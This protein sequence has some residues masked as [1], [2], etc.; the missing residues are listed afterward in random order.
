M[1]TQYCIRPAFRR[2]TALHVLALTASSFK[3]EATRVLLDAGAKPN[4]QDKQDRTVAHLLLTGKFPWYKADESLAMLLGAGTDFSLEDDRGQTPLHYLA[5]LGRDKP[6][7]FIRGITNCFASPKADISARDH[8]GDTPMHIAARTGTADGFEWLRAR[9][10]SLE[11]TN[12][13]GETPLGLAAHSTDPFTQFRFNSDTDIFRAAQVG[14]METL[15]ALLKADPGLVNHTNQFGQFPLLVAVQAHRTNAVAL[16]EAKGAKWDAVTA[17][18]AG[19]ADVLRGILAREPQALTNTYF[20][21]SLL[22][23]AADEGHVEVARLLLDDGSGLQATDSWGLSPLGAARLRNRMGVADLLAARGAVETVFDAVFNGHLQSAAA[24]LAR[25]KSLARAT[26]NY[27]A[28]VSEVAARTGREDILKLLLDKGAPAD[29]VNPRSGQTALHVAAFFDQ[30]GAAD[31][32]IRRGAKVDAADRSGLAPLHLAAAQ[33]STAAAALLLKHKADPDRRVAPSSEQARYTVGPGQSL[34]RAG[35]T[36]LHIAAWSGQ[37]NVIPL[38]LKA[39][40]SIN[41]TNSTGR[42]ALDLVSFQPMGP[43]MFWMRRGFSTSLNPP[44][45]GERD[46]PGPPGMFPQQRRDVASLLEQAGAKRSATS[47]SGPGRPGF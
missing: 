17:A 35:D 7:S 22:H 45:I 46:Q 4:V 40:A 47:P 12:N 25:D 36:P 1:G 33:G 42:T 41:A 9:G 10:A 32:L 43:A 38:L 44:G 39:G 5:A 21:R 15:T 19:R 8:Q 23:L 3:N 31:L 37:T 27:G 13:A 2:Q 18:M 11:A 20:G 29:W 26:N 28:S 6:L 34:G 24:L 16:L 14:N 30:A